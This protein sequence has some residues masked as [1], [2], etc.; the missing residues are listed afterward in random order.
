MYFFHLAASGLGCRTQGLRCW[1][2]DLCFRIRIFL[3][4][5]CELLVAVL[6]VVFSRWAMS[7]SFATSGTV[8]HQAPL[9][10]G[11][12]RQE[13]WNGLPFP[14]QGI[15]LTQGSKLHLLHWQMDSSPLSHLLCNFLVVR[16]LSRVLDCSMAGKP[17]CLLSVVAS[18]NE[19]G[20]L[21]W[22]CGVL[23]TGPPG[24]SLSGNSC[25]R[26]V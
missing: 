1:V 17:S 12:P 4:A 11:F 15:F 26:Y 9:S 18:G 21:L 10:V 7:A 24:K 5:A 20:L 23:S 25:L 19:P 8:T 6:V 22:E 13:Y 16:S 3:V 2:W 14:S